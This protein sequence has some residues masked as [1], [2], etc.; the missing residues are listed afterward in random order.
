[1]SYKR[2]EQIVIAIIGI[3]VAVFLTRWA[4]QAVVYDRFSNR[5][6]KADH[7]VVSDGRDSIIISGEKVGKIAMAIASS[8]RDTLHYRAKFSLMTSFYRGTNCLGEIDICNNLFMANG[9]QYRA[10]EGD[11]KKL[12]VEPF[13][14]R[15]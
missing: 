14:K 7:I 15:N 13:I 8:S 10:K 2:Y 12:V 6:A 11:L 1:M 5:I 9:Y 3:C 4:W